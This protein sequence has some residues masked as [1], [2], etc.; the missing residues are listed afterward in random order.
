MTDMSIAPRSRNRQTITPGELARLD[1]IGLLLEQAAGTLFLMI[2]HGED[3]GDW[4]AWEVA[5]AYG[6]LR[7]VDDAATIAARSEI[8]KLG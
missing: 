6:V 5:A 1:R 8:G 4:E 3:A 2:K 7:M